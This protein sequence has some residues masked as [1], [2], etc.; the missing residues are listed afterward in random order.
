MNIKRALK[1]LALWWR[2]LRF[3][4][5]YVIADCNDNSITFSRKLYR[6][7]EL[8]SH[9]EERAQVY[10]FHIP[11]WGT[12]GF[13]VNPELKKEETQLA[14]IQFNEKYRT[15]GFESLCPTVNWIFNHYGLPGEMKMKLT[16]TIRQLA[17]GKVFYNIE[18]PRL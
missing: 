1:R 17:D 6:H 4:R 18:R 3:F 15:I 14:D 11:A 12:Y 5:Y 9:C 2:S 10:V 13:V 8:S 16:V 7:I